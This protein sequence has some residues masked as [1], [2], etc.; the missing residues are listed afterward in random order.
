MLFCIGTHWRLGQVTEWEQQSMLEDLAGYLQETGHLDGLAIMGSLP[1]GVPR[2][3]Y[4]KVYT[5]CSALM[6]ASAR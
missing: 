2:D 5:M 1:L 3:F 4:A 6:R